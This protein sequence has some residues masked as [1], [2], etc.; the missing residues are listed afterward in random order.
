[1]FIQWKA[2]LQ[3]A[4]VANFTYWGLTNMF[5]QTLTL[6]A[7]WPYTPINPT[8]GSYYTQE[9][10][11]VHRFSL[12]VNFSE[13]SFSLRVFLTTKKG[14]TQFKSVSRPPPSP[15]PQKLFPLHIL[16]LQAGA[17]VPKKWCWLTDFHC[18]LTSESALSLRVFSTIRKRTTQFKSVSW[19]P[20][21]PK[22]Q[23]PFPLPKLTGGMRRPRA[24]IN[25][26]VWHGVHKK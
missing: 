15:K 23:K 7:G 25:D 6:E 20:P 10:V 19:P 4:S 17:T 3:V 22:P 16:T 14:T 26:R 24:I 9:M 12:W 11:L 21:S 5:S 8:S 2:K 18:K 13:S 1:M